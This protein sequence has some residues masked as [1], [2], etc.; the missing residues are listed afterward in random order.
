MNLQ[1]KASLSPECVAFLR[2]RLARFDFR[3][4]E[5]FRL[6]D[7]TNASVTVG[8]WGRCKYPNRKKKLGYRSACRKANNWPDPKPQ[9]VST[10]P[11]SLSTASNPPGAASANTSTA[12]APGSSQPIPATD[13]CSDHKPASGLAAPAE[14]AIPNW[15][16]ASR[17][18]F[19]SRRRPALP[20]SAFTRSRREWLPEVPRARP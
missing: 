14:A 11:A 4:L 20:S 8:V 15:V 5:Y 13:A 9:A 10:H 12:S 2:G 18:S 3:H 7:R 19:C 6:Y 16:G 1:I 17:Q